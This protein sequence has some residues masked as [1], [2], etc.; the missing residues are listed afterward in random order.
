MYSP[1]KK[2]LDA[3]NLEV[4]FKQTQNELEIA[5]KLLNEEKQLT[6]KLQ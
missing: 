4:L 2:K 1:D 3:T 5:K 6:T